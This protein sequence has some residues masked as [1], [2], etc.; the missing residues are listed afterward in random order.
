[1]VYPR[2]Y[3]EPLRNGSQNHYACYVDNCY[4]MCV[5]I[6]TYTHTHMFFSFFVCEYY[7]RHK[8]MGMSDITHT[9][10]APFSSIAGAGHF[11]HF[12]YTTFSPKYFIIFAY[13]RTLSNLVR[14]KGLTPA[15]FFSTLSALKSSTGS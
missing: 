2:I 9:Q 15:K 7:N 10:E 11:Y 3:H 8:Q 5:F 4:F 14:Q 6:Y 13:P 12:L 1:M